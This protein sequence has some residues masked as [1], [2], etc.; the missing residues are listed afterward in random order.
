MISLDLPMPPSIWALYRNWGKS[1][2]RSEVYDEWLRSAG[3]EILA[4]PLERRQ[5]IKGGF[6]FVL[7]LPEAAR[8]FKNGK[9]KKIDASNYIKAPEDLLVAHGLVD[10][11][12]RNE[13]GSFGWS[14]TVEP[15]RIRVWVF[16]FDAERAAIL[17]VPGEAA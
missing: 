17:Q 7:L 13:T 3:N 14:K 16:P 8:W 2:N 15:G 4:T 6:T 1:R 5:P 11:D 10:D 9:R 12:H